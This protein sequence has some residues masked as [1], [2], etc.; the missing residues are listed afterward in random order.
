MMVLRD[1]EGWM[2]MSDRAGKDGW[3]CEIE[4]VRVDGNVK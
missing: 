1:R 4:R 2:A 3:Q